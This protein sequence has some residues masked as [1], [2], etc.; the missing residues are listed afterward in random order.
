MTAVLSIAA[1]FVLIAICFSCVLPVILVLSIELAIWINLSIT[2][3][4]GTEA[5]L[6]ISMVVNCVQ[7]VPTVDYTAHHALS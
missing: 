3:I 5:S 6:S 4:M 1:I 7:L 2:V